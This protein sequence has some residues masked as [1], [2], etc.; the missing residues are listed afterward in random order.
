MTGHIEFRHHANA[1][2]TSVRHD[3]ADFCLGVVLAVGAHLLKFGKFQ[4]LDAKSLVIGEVPVQHIHLDG[5]HGIE[6]SFENFHRLEVAADIDQQ[7]APGKSRLI[8]DLDS[9]QKISV[10]IALKQL[11]KSLEAAERT[12]DCRRD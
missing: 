4:A 7:S 11:Q 2:I 8:L 5:S 6:I 12:Y 10:A 3:V 1:A 9:R